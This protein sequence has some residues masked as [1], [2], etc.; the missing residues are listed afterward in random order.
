MMSNV[1]RKIDAIFNYDERQYYNA[2]GDKVEEADNW[3]FPCPKCRGP[4]DMV[5]VCAYYESY[6]CLNC[7]HSFTVR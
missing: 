3:D 6:E 5:D 4:A 1:E 2:A 7:G